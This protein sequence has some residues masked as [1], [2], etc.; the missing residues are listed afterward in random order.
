MKRK[1]LYI[2]LTVAV[3][4]TAFFVGKNIDQPATPHTPENLKLIE[5]TGTTSGIYLDYTGET[6]ETFYSFTITAE[7]LEK[8]GFINVS[9]IKGWEHWEEPENVG[10][11]IQGENWTYI[12]EKQP[13]TT[14]TEVSRLY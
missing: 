5:L 3:S 7:E 12:V 8:Q 11:E 9:N 13:Y 4:V 14:D 6:E 10:I 2:V 1:I